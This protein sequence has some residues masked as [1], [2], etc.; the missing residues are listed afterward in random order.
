MFNDEEDFINFFK[1]NDSKENR[2]IILKTDKLKFIYCTKFRV[3]EKV[4]HSIE[5]DEWYALVL[6]T[7][8]KRISKKKFLRLARERFKKAKALTWKRCLRHLTNTY[9]QGEEYIRGYKIAS[10]AISYFDCY[11]RMRI[12]EFME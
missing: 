1:E 8:R 9:L 10:T 7:M 4:L 6:V 3:R 12:E 2:S 11:W 5:S